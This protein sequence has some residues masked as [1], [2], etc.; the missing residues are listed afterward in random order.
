MTESSSQ[1]DRHPHGQVQ[2]QITVP[3]NNARVALLGQHDE[4]LKAIEHAVPT[5]EVHVRGNVMT[6]TGAPGDAALAERLLDELMQIARSAQPLSADAVERAI[7]ILTASTTERPAQVLTM[8]ILSSRGRTI[9]PKT[10]GQKDYV[11]AIDANTVVFGI[12]D[13]KS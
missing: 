12:G 13:R 7:T 8:N 5:V 6:L 2:Q 4:V 11:Q 9:R 3:D 1:P 10:V